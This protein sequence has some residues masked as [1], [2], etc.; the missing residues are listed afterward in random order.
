MI[1]ERFSSLD[2]QL[3]NAESLL[4]ELTGYEKDE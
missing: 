3:E 4:D 2:N 1:E